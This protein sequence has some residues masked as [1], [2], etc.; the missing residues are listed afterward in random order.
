MAAT[1][2]TTPARRS[3]ARKRLL[4]A[5]TELFYSEGINR[6]GVDR[7][8]AAADTTLATFYRHFPSKQDL[9]V[10]YLQAIHDSFAER[11]EA[12]A[13]EG[14]ELI[15]EAGA[16]VVAEVGHEAFRGCAFINAASEFEDP[17]SPVRKAVAEHRK[18]YLERLRRA[19]TEAG[20]NRPGNAARHFVMLRDGAVT[21]GYL[22][23]PTAAQR[24]FKRGVEGLIRAIDIDHMPEHVDEA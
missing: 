23:S 14:R 22:D 11:A 5:A 15:A 4:A 21:A 20:H 19:F 2:R 16:E 24:T 3:E 12:S 1:N 13:K 17:E 8:V 7:I 18:W 9:V 6:V 10:G